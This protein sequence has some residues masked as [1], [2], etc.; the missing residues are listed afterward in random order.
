MAIGNTVDQADCGNQTSIAGGAGD[1]TTLVLLP[2]LQPAEHVAKMS[3][4]GLS[5]GGT[6]D[7][8]EAIWTRP[9]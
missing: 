6:P 3:E 2:L 1:K 5:T 9:K 4:E 7:K 8:L